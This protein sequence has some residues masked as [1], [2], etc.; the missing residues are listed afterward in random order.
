MDGV[1]RLTAS[2]LFAIGVE[3]DCRGKQFGGNGAV[4]DEGAGDARLPCLGG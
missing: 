1:Q 3:F 4:L 2:F